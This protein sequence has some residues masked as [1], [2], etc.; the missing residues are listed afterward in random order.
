[1]VSDQNAQAVLPPAAIRALVTL[2]LDS[3]DRGRQTGPETPH[4]ERAERP[5]KMTVS[6]HESGSDCTHP[7]STR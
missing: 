1:M 7:E 5:A 4:H 3:A 2:L 6:R